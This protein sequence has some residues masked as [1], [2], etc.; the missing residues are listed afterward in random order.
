MAAAREAQSLQ[1]EQ[2]F[3]SWE[4]RLARRPRRVVYWSWPQR[5]WAW[6]GHRR[7]HPGF[8]RPKPILTANRR[9]QSRRSAPGEPSPT[10]SRHG[11]VDRQPTPICSGRPEMGRPP[12]SGPANSAALLLATA[13]IRRGRCGAAFFP[14]PAVS[15]TGRSPAVVGCWIEE[16]GPALASSSWQPC[17]GW[18]R[19]PQ[20]L[21]GGPQGRPARLVMGCG[22]GDEL[23]SNRC[24]PPTR[25]REFRRGSAGPGLQEFQGA[26]S[27]GRRWFASW[28]HH[29]GE[30]VWPDKSAQQLVLEGLSPTAVRPEQDLGCHEHAA[31]TGIR[32]SEHPTLVHREASA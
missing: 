11:A 1:P 31:T 30:Q 19:S 17:W 14:R 22:G 4:P 8:G 12:S 5:L 21:C 15:A 6:Q 10:R 20:T 26:H 23:W 24:A 29:L 18:N 16:G 25:P 9:P 27:G 3:K 32:R 2:A 7:A 13:W 28:N